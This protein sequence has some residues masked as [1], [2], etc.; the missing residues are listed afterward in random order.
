MLAA[1]SGRCAGNAGKIDILQRRLS[2]V[3]LNI[4]Q[5]RF[6]CGRA[7]SKSGLHLSPLVR[8]MIRQGPALSAC[9]IRLL[10]RRMALPARPREHANL[11]HLRVQRHPDILFVR[12]QNIDIV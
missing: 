2:L 5:K 4:E 12:G 6:F 3:L 10:V 7:I 8:R 11:L 1:K 9:F